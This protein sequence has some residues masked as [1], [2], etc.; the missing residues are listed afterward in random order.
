MVNKRLNSY[1]GRLTPAQ[2]AEGINFARHNSIRLLEDARIL[3]EKDR[4]PSAAALAILSIEES[5]KRS[6]LREISLVKSD[7][8]LNNTWKD[9]RSH[10]KKNVQWRLFDMVKQGA[11]K[12]EDFKPMFDPSAQHPYLLDNIKQLSIYT[13]CLGQAHWSSPSE[14]LDKD[15]VKDL[16][17]IAE[18]LSLGHDVTVKEIELWVKHLKDAAP[19]FASQKEAVLHWY[20]DMEINGLL[21]SDHKMKDVMKWL[22][23]DFDNLPD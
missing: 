9:Y 13:D 17:F 19:S 22:G 2:I 11:R 4:Y 5:G 14:T 18:A 20:Y 15:F 21:P 8:E 23:F 12:L 6:I 16:I 3:Y 1:K 10:I 7:K